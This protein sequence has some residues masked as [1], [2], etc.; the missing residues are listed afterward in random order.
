[1]DRVLVV[2]APYRKKKDHEKLITFCKHLDVSI[3]SVLVTCS[4]E[5][6]WRARFKQ[7]SLDPQPNQTITDYD[8]MKG[9]YGSMHIEPAIGEFVFDS[10]G[11]IEVQ[12]KKL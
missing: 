7:R 6:E 12:Y 2:D 4:D 3:K 10:C 1:M 11:D 8:D 5:E 9:L